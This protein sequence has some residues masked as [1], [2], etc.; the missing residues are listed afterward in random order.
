VYVNPVRLRKSPA[1]RCRSVRF[2]SGVISRGQL[3][4]SHP[5][6]RVDVLPRR[7][8]GVV[9]L[10]VV[11]GVERLERELRRLEP[12]RDVEVARDEVLHPTDRRTLAQ[13]APGKRIVTCASVHE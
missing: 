6:R 10:V 4:S 8:P 1:W 11:L 3:L 2:S 5:G 13:G 12:P 7:G 9:V